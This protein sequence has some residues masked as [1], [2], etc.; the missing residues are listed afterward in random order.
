MDKLL[1]IKLFVESVDA[2]GFSAA[3]RK[4]GLAT[5]SVSRA[6]DA[7]ENQLGAT[8]L[9]RS[10][11]QISVTDAGAR[12]YHK[13]RRLLEDLSEADAEVADR[14]LEPVGSLR[15]CVP[16][17]FG[18]RLIAPHLGQLLKRY[19]ELTVD[20][21]LSDRFDDLLDGRFDVAIRLGA[22]APDAE[23]VCRH[24]ADFQR[25]T[26]ASPAYLSAHGQPQHP[27]HLSAHACLRFNY[28][29]AR[30]VWRFSHG[31]EQT[32]VPIQGRLRSDN[33]DVLRQAAIDDAGIALLADWLVAED[34][35]A[36]RLV[37]VL[38]EWDGTPNR[39]SNAINA[40]YLPNH[41]GSRRVA[42]FIGFLQDILAK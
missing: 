3:A 22:A 34:I 8:L 37:R 1:A 14:G 27:E 10:T 12:Y 15:V 42:A 16:V 35:S 36:G 4:L 26:V 2:Q 31:D 9:N 24:L 30:Q 39:A 13:A 23:V 32:D 19:P 17:E 7:L 38:E 11:R 33:A 41:R 6:I 25:W 18:R 40:L 5:S 29:T 20:I 28:G 21:T